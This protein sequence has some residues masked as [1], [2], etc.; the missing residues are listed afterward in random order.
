MHLLYTDETNMDPARSTFLIYGGV[1]FSSDRASSVSSNID[2]LRVVYGY[3]PE[4]KLKFTSYD[5]PHISRDVHRVIK[6]AV[7][8]CSADHDG[9]IFLSM[10]NHKV[11]TSPDEARRNEINRVCYHF[12]CY[13]HRVNDYGVVLV[14]N[15][16]D[17]ELIPHLREKFGVGLRGLPYSPVLRLDRILGFH[18][19]SIGTSHFS[20]VVDIAIGGVRYAINSIEDPLKHKT[21]RELLSQV[22][23]LCLRDAENKVSELSI[24]YSPNHIRVPAY[25]KD[26]KQ[27]DEFLAS[28]GINTQGK[29]SE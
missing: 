18:V 5:C 22:S 13:L 11:A 12:N 25:L 21:G 28:A 20:S 7:M 24:F 14:D 15:F 1:A 8:K 19:A 3:K 29:P 9:V 2:S 27:V 10:I 23:P 26:Y 17:T 6:Q 16:Q 4:D